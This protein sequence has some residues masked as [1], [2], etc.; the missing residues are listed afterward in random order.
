MNIIRL[1]III[2]L[3]L[4]WT[5]PFHYA[6][7][8]VAEN[9]FFILAIPLVLSINLIKNKKLKINE[10]IFLPLMLFIFSCIQYFIIDYYFLEDFILISIYSLFLVFILISSQFYNSKE[11]I[12]FFLKIIVLLCLIN[13]FIVLS[14]FFNIKSI[15]ILE[16]L[17]VRRFYANI[18]QPNHL[19]TLFIT[20]IVATLILYRHQVIRVRTLYIISMYLTFFVFLTGSRTGV[21]L[22][23]ILLCLGFIFRRREYKT[24]NFYFFGFLFLLYIIISYYFT[25]NSR[26][27]LENIETTFSDSRFLLW[28]D[29]VSSIL[30]NPWIGYGINGV[31]TSRL[32]S[33]L[34]FKM[35]YVSSHNIFI[36]FFLWF[37]V[38]GGILFLI[39][40]LI[41]F[42]RIYTNKKN[43][44]EVLLFLTPFIVHSLF[45]YPF[46]Y[47]YFLVLVIPAFT[48]ITGKMNFYIHR[49]VFILMIS[50]YMALV[51]L[52]YIDFEHYSRGAFFAHTQKCESTNGDPIVLDLMEKYSQLYCG[53]LS[54][55]DMRRVVYR[56]AY[57]IHIKYYI[58][59]GNND[60]KL[61]RFE[62]KIKK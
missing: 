31:R 43:G 48:L 38:V 54:S 25:S 56:Y 18:G 26:N 30:E 7:W 16:H 52:I 49:P 10:F 13:S 4:A 58:E 6:P 21:L 22:L 20:G 59:S 24:L 15:F 5:Y 36:D 1:I 46:R 8:A 60:E 32:F 12:Y 42:K 27:T 34:N 61:M 45:E 44:Y 19:S 55:L 53:T 29:S 62:Q 9:E 17:G 57:P 2:L 23:L 14:Q 35:P 40:S 51:S 47:L 11:N 28:S 50:M 33:N 39:Y 37:G 41:I 3:V